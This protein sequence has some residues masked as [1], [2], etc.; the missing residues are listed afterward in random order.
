MSQKLP[1]NLA[2]NIM[3]MVDG[4][5]TGKPKS[6]NKMYDI[7]EAG[8]R[9]NQLVGAAADKADRRWNNAQEA[10]SRLP[11]QRNTRARNGQSYLQYGRTLWTFPK[12]C[13][14]CFERACLAAYLARELNVSNVFI[15]EITTPGDHVFCLIGGSGA[16]W[17]SVEQMTGATTDAWV[18]DPWAAIACPAREYSVHFLDTLDTW[19]ARGMRIFF[20]DPATPNVARWV[21]PTNIDYA[22]GFVYGPLAFTKL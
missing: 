9:Q 6:G 12:G 16:P 14:N 17:N 13:G 10:N 1:A 3:T 21:E 22:N 19:T 4:F 18:L 20:P 5:Y 15:G 11:A 2:T 8:V 7:N